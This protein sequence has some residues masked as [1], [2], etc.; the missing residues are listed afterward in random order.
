MSEETFSLACKVAEDRGDYISIGGGEP[1]LHPLFWKFIAKAIATAS[2]A[3]TG[4]WLA[5]NGSR[6]EDSLT[7]AAM[8]KSGVISCALSQDQYHEQISPEVV[9]AF[10]RK[11]VEGDYYT[12][13]NDFREIRTINEVMDYGRAKENGLGET[14][15]CPCDD[16]FVSPTGKI[17][18]CACKLECYGTVKRDRI[19]SDYEAQCA[20]NKEVACLTLAQSR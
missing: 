9:K 16:L 2:R 4:V 20:R 10:S 18:S 5:T 19:P 13:Q 15:R 8:A 1:T 6:T 3:G 7:L 14:D 11:K 12:G 17:Y